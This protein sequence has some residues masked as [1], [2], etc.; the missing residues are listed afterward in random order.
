MKKEQ[1]DINLIYPIDNVL[2]TQKIIH[3]S[4]QPNSNYYFFKEYP[5]E[6]ELKLEPH[7]NKIKLQE[8]IS[9]YYTTQ[10]YGMRSIM[11]MDPEQFLEIIKQNYKQV[12]MKFNIFNIKYCKVQVISTYDTIISLNK[13]QNRHISLDKTISI[14]KPN[15]CISDQ[16][17]FMTKQVF[18]DDGG[19]PVS[20][21]GEQCNF[22]M[23][24]G[25]MELDY[26]LYES[27]KNYFGRYVL[28]DFS[29]I[30]KNPQTSH[31][32][33]AVMVDLFL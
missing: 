3:F 5:S 25:Y 32:I 30:K 7:I 1:F 15:G 14:F 16:H 24:N 18:V 17:T 33:N 23:T 4:N 22:M 26:F 31:Y 19:F 10:D 12:K 6:I 28:L 21:F 20:V 13:I 2:K 29:Y 27:I 9:K 8:M 11:L